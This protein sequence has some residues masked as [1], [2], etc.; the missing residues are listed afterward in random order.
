MAKD[1]VSIEN[2]IQRIFKKYPDLENYKILKGSE[3]GDKY[4]YSE[5]AA[6]INKCWDHTYKN[7]KREKKARWK[8]TPGYLEW[9]IEANSE[10]RHH[11][12][13]V[14]DRDDNWVGLTCGFTKKI[15][16]GEE[17]KCSVHTGLSVDPEKTKHGIA[18]LIHHTGF[19]MDLEL[20]MDTGLFWYDGLNNKKGHSL[21]IFRNSDKEM[22]FYPY[23]IMG[24]I[25]DSERAIKNV[26]LPA[27]QKTLMKIF[28]GIPKASENIERVNDTCDFDEIIHFITKERIDIKKVGFYR[29]SSEEIRRLSNFRKG[30]F[31]ASAYTLRLKGELAGFLQGFRIPISQKNED[32]IFNIDNIIL[33]KSIQKKMTNRFLKSC[34]NMIHKEENVYGV[35]TVSGTYPTRYMGSRI[36]YPLLHP[37]SLFGKRYVFMGIAPFNPSVEQKLGG[38]EHFYIDQK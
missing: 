19:K 15:F 34:L 32:Y 14:F 27:Y 23:Q 5:M 12:M 28:S 31:S 17:I 33:A 2:N 9:L 36:F 24:T 30:E 11:T 1:L 7:K 22:S 18:Q 35:V 10:N 26:E 29:Y 4:D 38:I 3:I 25:F 13:F 8:F 37:Q 6:F 20:G 21:T 16:V